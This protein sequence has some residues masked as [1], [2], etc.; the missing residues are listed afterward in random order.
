VGGSTATA[1]EGQMEMFLKSTRYIAEIIRD[2]F[3]K[4]CIPQLVDWNFEVDAYPELRVR[5]IGDTQDWRTLS[6]AL[7]NL[8]GAGI[9]QVD[10]PLEDWIRDEMDLP[11]LD[12]TT[13]REVATPQ[14]VRVGPPRQ[15][16]APNMRTQQSRRAGTDR[17][18]ES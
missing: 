13:V 4:Y 18:G 6:F 15:S 9:V 5:R 16:P 10:Q 12:P 8:T 14:A 17:S 7:R 11:R 3:N 1:G 2:V